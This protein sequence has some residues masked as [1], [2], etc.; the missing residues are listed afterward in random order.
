MGWC[1]VC[2]ARATQGSSWTVSGSGILPCFLCG[3]LPVVKF[4]KLSLSG[5]CLPVFSPH[6]WLIL[7][8]SKQHLFKGVVF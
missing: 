6:L 1:F 3:I 7:Y 8:S 2:S 4:E 5:V